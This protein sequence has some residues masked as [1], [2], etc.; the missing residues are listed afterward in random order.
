[1]VDITEKTISA[2]MAIATT[3]MRLPEIFLNF[4]QN[5]EIL[6]KKGPVF[7]TA[8]I[9]GTSAVK[10]TYAVIPFCHQIP[11]ES[12]KFDIRIENL[13]ITI[14]CTVKTTS[15]TGVEMEAMHGASVAA[16]TIY[17]MC[18]AISH[19]IVI[20]ETKLI[21]KTGGK[22]LVLDR[23]LYGLV[24]TGGKS[25]RMGKDKALLHYKGKAHAAYIYDL[26]NEYCDKT[27]LS[28][29]AGQW[30]N[31]EL[32]EL[33]SLVDI[34]DGLGPTSGI[35]T[36]LDTHKDA[37]WLIIAC[38]LIYFSHDIIQTLLQNIDVGKTAICFK[39]KEK[40]FPEA[41]CALYTPE[42]Y[43]LFETAIANNTRCPVKILK[44]GDCK[45][46]EQTGNIDLANINSLAEF[47]G[48][49]LENHHS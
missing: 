6:T 1:M 49:Q 7:Q 19:E 39:N 48:V 3:S 28:S 13:L 30:D 29:K 47:K 22:K 23:P 11:I 14:T 46:L 24:L 38:D 17:D 37:Y 43:K 5:N 32:S 15:K 36:A 16:L 35:W 18:K 20:G 26:L 2:R 10:N 34:K 40:H 9:A 41:L 31:T 4:I 8:I 44:D 25:E 12:C 33:N 45:I 42:A 21:T 27:Y